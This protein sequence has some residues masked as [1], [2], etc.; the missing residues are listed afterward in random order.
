MRLQIRKLC[1]LKFHL[2]SLSVG[3]SICVSHT[4]QEYVRIRVGKELRL[5]ENLDH[6]CCVIFY[7]QLLKCLRR[8]T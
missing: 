8:F 2:S 1:A 5:F 6:D 3:T 4:I 7:L